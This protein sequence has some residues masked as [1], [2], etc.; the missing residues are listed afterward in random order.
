MKLQISLHHYNV[1]MTISSIN[2]SCLNFFNVFFRYYIDNCQLCCSD[3]LQLVFH[4]LKVVWQ[5]ATWFSNGITHFST[6]YERR[7]FSATNARY[8]A[9]GHPKHWWCQTGSYPNLCTFKWPRFWVRYIRKKL[10]PFSISKEFWKNM[11]VT[12]INPGWAQNTVHPERQD[13]SST[14]IS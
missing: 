13:Y 14:A 5:A 2:K 12:S 9:S 8:W 10:K 6:W 4:M 11:F 3:S 7:A 1:Q